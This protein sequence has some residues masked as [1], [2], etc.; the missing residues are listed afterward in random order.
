M[1]YKESTFYLYKMYLFRLFY[2]VYKFLNILSID[3]A[4]GSC[5][6]AYFISKVF[7][8]PLSSITYFVL[9]CSVWIIYTADHL[10]DASSLKDYSIAPRHQFHYKHMRLLKYILIAITITTGILTINYLPLNTI[11]Y[12]L[13]TSV[14]VGSHLA[15]VKFL[16][17]TVSIFVQKELS[18]ALTYTL[19]ISIPSISLLSEV[20]WFHFFILVQCFL[21]AFINLCEFSFFDFTTDVKSSQTSIARF[22]GQKK[23]SH[24]IYLL[25]SIYAI[26]TSISFIFFSNTNFYLYEFFLGI[27]WFILGFIFI[28]YHYFKC[29]ERYRLLGDFVFILPIFL[30]I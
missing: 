15:L 19:G 23:S 9:F 4:I 27:I 22:L 11:I 26:I 24:F 8:T 18:V 5:T 28:Q 30:L 3:V 1:L 16:G 6:M 14:L 2:K 20:T 13:V 21:L 7:L 10:L 17:N 25:L 12:G 29:N